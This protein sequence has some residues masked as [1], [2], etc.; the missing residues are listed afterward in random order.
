MSRL[1]D[2]V[3]AAAAPRGLPCRLCAKIET[4]PATEAEAIRGA[5]R[6]GIAVETL[7]DILRDNDHTVPRREIT[8]HK[9]EGHSL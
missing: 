6:N 1:S 3:T 9:R 2:Q 7:Y 5:L 8:K 4:L